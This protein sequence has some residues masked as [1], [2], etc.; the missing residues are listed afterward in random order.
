MGRIRSHGIKKASF[1]LI[2]Y[3]PETFSRDFE[4]NKKIVTEINITSEKRA[5]NK[6]AGYISRIKGHAR[7]PAQ[8][9]S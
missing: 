9:S 3:N 8:G 2:K 5:R 6:I 7:A 4:G 1:D